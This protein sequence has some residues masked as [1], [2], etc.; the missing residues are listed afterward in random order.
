MKMDFKKYYTDP[1]FP[2]SFSGVQTFYKALKE[3]NPS[4]KKEDV[5]NFL[6]TS[7]VY[8]LHKPVNKPKQY[9][10]VYTKGINYMYQIDLV[11]MSKYSR[12]NKGFKFLITM[13]DSFSKYAWVIPI[14]SKEGVNVYKGL[15]AILLVKRP[16][17]IQ[18][19][20]GSEFYNKRFLNMLTVFGIKWYSTNSEIKAGIVERFNRTLK[21]RMERV[22]TSQ[23]NHRYIDKIQDLVKS[24][25]NTVHRSIG[26]KPAKVTASDTKKILLKL[27]PKKKKTVAP[28]FKVG[29]SKKKKKKTLAPEFKVGDTVRI[30]RKKHIFQKGYEQG[31]SYEVF[32]VAKILKTEPITY[33]LEDYKKEVIVG[34]FYSSELQKVTPVTYPIEKIV[35]RRKRNDKVELLVKWLGYPKEANSWI[36]QEDLFRNA[37]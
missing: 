35:R 16:Q 36:S 30:T 7:D 10:R 6:K 3:E 34:S 26:M 9:R 14:K 8:T 27:Y 25:N 33:E 23:G 11:D 2:G 18:M 17:K 20:R 37:D 21:T 28:L 4:V 32:T 24:Y 1:S 19:D 31:W 29:D 15:K 22:F 12:E 5:E 13:I